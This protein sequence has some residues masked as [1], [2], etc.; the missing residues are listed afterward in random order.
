MIAYEVYVNGEKVCVAS[1]GE[2]GVLTAILSWV[3]SR[4][5]AKNDLLDLRIGGLVHA[6]HVR[7]LSE[8]TTI[9]VGD[10]V[11]IRVVEITALSEADEPRE[12]G[13]KRTREQKEQLTREHLQN[14]RALL[15]SP[16]VESETAT[17]KRFDYRLAEGFWAGAMNIL[18]ELGELNEVP[19]GFWRE[20]SYTAHELSMH[21]DRNRYSAKWQQM[22]NEQSHGEHDE[23]RET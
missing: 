14:A 20:L 15:P 4:G 17:L 19:F 6:D 3:G 18:D 22:R 13:N 10:E 1:V 8:T 9:S 21:E 16:L 12:R 5:S 7:W 11:T 2:S 23:T